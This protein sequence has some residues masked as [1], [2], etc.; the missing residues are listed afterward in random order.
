MSKAPDFLCFQTGTDGY[1]RRV[2]QASQLRFRNGGTTTWKG[3]ISVP[4][5][6]AAL[7]SPDDFTATGA[8][9]AALANLE[10]RRESYRAKSSPLLYR[11]FPR[12]LEWVRNVGGGHVDLDLSDLEGWRHEPLL[13]AVKQL[14]AFLDD[15]TAEPGPLPPRQD[16]P[17]VWRKRK[18]ATRLEDLAWPD[19]VPLFAVHSRELTDVTVGSPPFRTGPWPERRFAEDEFAPLDPTQRAA[20][21]E[22]AELVRDALKSCDRSGIG[23]SPRPRRWRP[24]PQGVARARARRVSTGDREARSGRRRSS[25]SRRWIIGLPSHRICSVRLRLDW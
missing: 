21:Q 22:R 8:R 25:G 9:A 20:I 10:R 12:F 19:E 6:W 4:V 3:G 11:G 13:L 14:I 5:L 23:R 16:A 7:F 24:G 15:V 18:G 17:V 1:L 2:H